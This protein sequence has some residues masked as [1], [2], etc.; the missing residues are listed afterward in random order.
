MLRHEYSLRTCG[1]ITWQR[2]Q[3]FRLPKSYCSY[4]YVCDKHQLYE[5]WIK[6]E[7]ENDFIENAIKISD[8]AKTWLQVAEYYKEK[9][10]YDNAGKYYEKENKLD[11]AINSFL[12][13]DN[14]EEIRRICTENELWSKLAEIEFDYKNYYNAGINFEKSGDLEKAIDSFLKADNLNEV[15]RICKANKMWG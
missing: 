13:S 15:R 6:A 3:S 1:E 9:N 14:L 5:P 11:D 8:K 7:L 2:E 12:Q 10:E 4:Q